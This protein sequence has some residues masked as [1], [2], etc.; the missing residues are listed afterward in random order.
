MVAWA[1]F[2]I[3]GIIEIA[4]DNDGWHSE[5]EHVQHNNSKEKE[6]GGE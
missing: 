6:N 3:A 2:M 1:F 5:T 4:Q